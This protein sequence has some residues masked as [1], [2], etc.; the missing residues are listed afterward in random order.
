MKRP[1]RLRVLHTT[2]IILTLAATMLLL[3]PVQRAFHRNMEELHRHLVSEI[4]SRLNRTISYSRITPSILSFLEIHDLSVHGRDHERAELL[5]VG[6]VRTHF[7]LRDLFGF[8]DPN[9]PIIQRVVLDNSRLSLDIERDRDLLEFFQELAATVPSG[10]SSRTLSGLRVDARNISLKLRS[11]DHTVTADD[12]AVALS[13]AGEDL[14][15]RVSS[16]VGYDR[17][18]SVETPVELSLDLPR[19][20]R[21]N[22]ESEGSMRPDLSGADFDLVLNELF[23]PAL[24]VRGFRFGILYGDDQVELRNLP[25]QDPIDLSLMIDLLER[26]A[27]LRFQAQDYNPQRTVI[28]GD[29]LKA[30][31]PWLVEKVSGSGALIADLEFPPEPETEAS[32]ESEILPERNTPESALNAIAAV[33]YGAQLALD[34]DLDLNL[35]LTASYSPENLFVL[36]RA[37]GD[38]DQAFVQNLQASSTYSSGRAQFQGL[39]DIAQQA[40]RGELLFNDFRYRDSQDLNGRIRIDR[41]TQG[42]WNFSS[43]RISYGEGVV[44]ELSVNVVPT[45]ETVAVNGLFFLDEFAT[46]LIEFDGTVAPDRGPGFAG[47]VELRNVGATSIYELLQGVSVPSARQATPSQLQN[48][49]IDTRVSLETEFGELR[50][51]EAPY[52]SVFDTV[53]SDRYLSFSIFGEDN[54]YEV[55]DIFFGYGGHVVQGSLFGELYPN[56]V[57]RY[58]GQIMYENEVYELSGGFDPRNGLELV[59][60]RGL[61]VAAWPDGRGGYRFAAE[62][63]NLMLPLLPDN[64]ILGFDVSGEL[65]SLQDWA[66]TI[67]EIRYTGIPTLIGPQGTVVLSGNLGP[68]GGTLSQVRLEDSVANLVGSGVVSYGFASPFRVE[69]S[70][71]LFGE[72]IGE[73]YELD[74]ALYQGELE[75]ELR[76]NQASLRRLGQPN[77]RGALDGTATIQGSPTAPRLIGQLDIREGRYNNDPFFAQAAFD[78]SPARLEVTGIELRYLNSLLQAD[79]AMIDR[80]TRTVR[81]HGVF[82]HESRRGTTEMTVGIDGLFEEKESGLVL[83]FEDDFRAAV[84][85]RSSEFFHDQPDNEFELRFARSGGTVILD[86]GSEGELSGRLSSDGMFELQARDPFPIALQADGIFENGRLEANLNRIEISAGRVAH[87]LDFVEFAVLDAQITGSLRIVGPVN[88]P[89][90]FGTLTAEQLR[91]RL[92]FTPNEIT[93]ERVYLVFQEN[94]ITMNRTAVRTGEGQAF[95]NGGV[96]LNR[97]SP[98]E[99]RIEVETANESGVRITHDFQTVVVDGYGVGTLAVYGTRDLVNIRGD[100]TG[101]STTITLSENFDPTRS[102]RQGNTEFSVDIRVRTGRGVEFYWPTINFPLLRSFARSGEELHIQW[103]SINSRFSL[104]GAVG[105]QGGELFYFDRSFYI[106]EGRIVFNEDEEGFDP[107]L[108]ARAEVREFSDRGPVTI[109]MV[110]DNSRLSE[111]TPRFESNPM[112]PENEIAELLGGQV[113]GQTVGEFAAL[114]SAVLLTGDVAAQFGVMRRFETRVRDTLGL[115]LLSVRTPVFQNLVRGA[116][117]DRSEDIETQV[118]SLGG[119]LNNTSVFMGKYLGTDVFL[120]LLLRL[121]AVNQFDPNTRDIGGLAVDTELTLEFQTPFFLLEW[122]FFPRDIRE[123]YVR[124]NTFTFSWGFS[125]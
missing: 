121:Q 66:L 34:Y 58:S 39:V 70:I 7:R 120:E 37:S 8:G 90:F 23:T 35:G 91:S 71:A 30:Q 73:R 106:R 26:R 63:N 3:A 74:I 111:F 28:L 72:S 46:E 36:L 68:A 81:L 101:R 42:R 19:T 32:A 61:V 79:Q 89:E 92:T 83:P 1:T 94:T 20:V 93:A 75:G 114:S 115:D 77:I 49:R 95:A 65:R 44:H 10:E 51:L 5:R 41:E 17:I 33:L 21:A 60:P 119:Y 113:F 98:D 18:E 12:L 6:R 52:V 112:L 69:T 55:E 64:S 86:A 25:D 13:F 99:F 88:N 24:T 53:N 31:A 124:D 76:F 109:F 4:E 9:A 45:Q 16:V 96:V 105:I 29:E 117:E 47:S 2:L 97:W 103:D 125:Y 85:L 118:P 110:V 40:P 80:E 56:S 67:H 14:N 104:V 22:I 48:L 102:P 82:Q 11:G 15:F 122:G 27:E 62:A 57:V 87:L 38:E 43:P 50:E 116:V 107:L 78:L 54:T 84:R 100:F 123:L 108:S 59:T